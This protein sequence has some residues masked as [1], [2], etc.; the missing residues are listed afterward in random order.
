MKFWSCST[1]LAQFYFL[2][3]ILIPIDFCRLSLF[4]EFES[5]DF[6]ETELGGKKI[7]LHCPLSLPLHQLNVNFSQISFSNLSLFSLCLQTLGH[8]CDP[9]H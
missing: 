8:L 2:I 6:I 5:I 1:S 7:S 4:L 9:N 3:V